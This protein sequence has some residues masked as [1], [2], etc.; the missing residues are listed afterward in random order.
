MN[1]SLD[2][3]R[4]ELQSLVLRWRKSIGCV[5]QN[6]GPVVEDVTLYEELTSRRQRFFKHIYLKSKSVCSASQS[7]GFESSNSI[8]DV[9]FILRFVRWPRLL[10]CIPDSDAKYCR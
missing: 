10:W 2:N 3:D 4:P 1:I 8:Q 5:I 9:W 7:S 6:V